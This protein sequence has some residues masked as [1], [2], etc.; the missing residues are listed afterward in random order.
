MRQRSVES[1]T[2]LHSDI[3]QPHGCICQLLQRINTICA[4]R[5][6]LDLNLSILRLCDGDLFGAQIAIAG[7]AVFELGGEVDP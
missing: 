5:D 3:Q 6:D 1:A 2:R 7:F 4:A